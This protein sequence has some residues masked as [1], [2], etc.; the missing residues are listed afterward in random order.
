[1]RHFGEIDETIRPQLPELQGVKIYWMKKDDF[2]ESPRLCRW[3]RKKSS[4]VLAGSISLD[5]YLHIPQAHALIQPVD[6]SKTKRCAVDSH[7]NR[8]DDQD[9]E[10][11]SRTCTGCGGKATGTWY[12]DVGRWAVMAEESASIHVCKCWGLAC[13]GLRAH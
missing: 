10:R 2:N 12:P 5:R 3:K 11:N 13:A 6:V 9:T 7:S 1:M 8:G 4:T